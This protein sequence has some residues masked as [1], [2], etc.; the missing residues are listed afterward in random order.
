MFEQLQDQQVMVEAKGTGFISRLLGLGAGEAKT[1]LEAI[2]RFMAIIEFTPQGI[3]TDANLSFQK[4]MGYGLQE[5]VGKHHRMFAPPGV[6]DTD[7]YA[8]F[9]RDLARGIESQGEVERRGKGGRVVWLSAS[10]VPVRNSAGIVSSV[11]KICHEITARKNDDLRNCAI[12]DAID[13]T[14]LRIEFLP[15]G[16]IMDANEAFLT[17]TGYSMDEI[18]GRPH[19]TFVIPGSDDDDNYEIFWRELAQNNSKSGTFKRQNKAGDLVWLQAS[20]TPVLNS[21]GRVERVIKFATDQTAQMTRSAENDAQVKAIDRSQ[22]V[23]EFDLDSTIITANENFLSAMGYHLDEI[24]GRKHEIF[25]PAEDV[26]TA[27]YQQHWDDLRAGVTQQGEFKRIN[28]AGENVFINAVYDLV[29]DTDGNPSKVIKIARNITDRVKQ[30]HKVQRIGREVSSSVL[31]IQKQ[32][33]EVND[34]TQAASAASIQVNHVVQAVASAADEYGASAQE[35]ARALANSLQ[36]VDRVTQT[37]AETD[38]ATQ[39]LVD[40]AEQMN[41]ILSVIEGIAEQINLLSLNATIEAARA[42][43]AGRGFAVV[44]TEVK[45]LSGQ[46]AESTGQ[47]AKEISSLQGL[48]GDFVQRLSG[49]SSELNEINQNMSSVSSAV[50]EQSATSREITSNIQQAASGVGEVNESLSM[51]AQAVEESSRLASDTKNLAEQL[52][53]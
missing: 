51:I 4:T 24:V 1:K 11:V 36:S 16:T 41:G 20:Y 14:S 34:R 35:I 8:E 10:Y 31:D 39:Q 6:A 26:G 37:T 13:A 21:E 29:L 25:M 48:A 50:E 53:N 42:G 40:A 43:E 38:N 5:I 12:L 32:A 19:R 15:D 18:R 9:W 17:A 49:I 7:A 3:I 23:I 2:G 28:K 33:S 27:A 45:N 52:L 30:R 44:A 47:I 22:A 46:V